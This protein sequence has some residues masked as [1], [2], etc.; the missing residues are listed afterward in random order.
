MAATLFYTGKSI[1]VINSKL[2]WLDTSVCNL[3]DCKED[4]FDII[5]N[6]CIIKEGVLDWSK[7]GADPTGAISKKIIFRI[8]TT[9]ISWR[10]PKYC[11]LVILTERLQCCVTL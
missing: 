4:I 1:S 2:F 11:T 7:D 5:L 8:S 9:E 3:L 10:W 6:Y